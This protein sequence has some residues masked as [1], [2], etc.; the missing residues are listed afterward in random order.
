M[1][2]ALT[3]AMQDLEIERT[4]NRTMRAKLEAE[5]KATMETAYH[6]LLEDTFRRQMQIVEDK[7][8][9]DER[10]NLVNQRECLAQQL[11]SFLAVG[12]KQIYETR[13]V[14]AG[15]IYTIAPAELDL[16]RAQGEAEA[17]RKLRDQEAQLKLQKEKLVLRED[18]LTRREKAYKIHIRDA[19][20][21]ELRNELKL[22]RGTLAAELRKEIESEV[23]KRHT[24][25]IADAEYQR[26][27]EAGESGFKDE[28][29]VAGYNACQHTMG[30]LH[31][32]RTG[33]IP[34]DSPQLDFLMDA[35][36]PRNP[37]QIGIKMGK[38][39]TGGKAI[40]YVDM[41]VYH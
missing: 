3:K 15:A 31:K 4:T 41:Y 16:A 27:L 37:T 17:T 11:E 32:L 29:F 12:Q 8:K 9:L 34:H 23:E 28:G 19:L 36:H 13:D 33:K 26:G 7:A 25:R 24:I 21:A 10:T 35:D 30:V 20:E 39:E 18:N 40:R 38:L 22:G 1:Q 6:S 14:Q 2:A 5:V